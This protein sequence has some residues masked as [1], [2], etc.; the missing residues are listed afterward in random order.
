MIEAIRPAAY[1]LFAILGFLLIP[2][3]FW[4]VKR[5]LQ[6]HGTR[7]LHIGCGPHRLEGWLNTDLNPFHSLV[8]VDA[9]RRLPFDANAFD[10]IFTEHLIEHLEF[11]K[12]TQLLQECY[13]ILKAGGK[14][15][16]ATPNLQFLMDLYLPDKS[17]LQKQYIRDGMARYFPHLEMPFEAVVINH[18]FRAWGHQF[19][20]DFKTLEAEMKRAGFTGIQQEEVGESHDPRLQNLER[21]GQK[22]GQDY[23]KLET[24]VIEATKP[25]VSAPGR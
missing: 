11:R 6:S 22:I 21:H 25:F 20:Y 12:G 9:G 15:R 13:R 19:I 16:I 7:K 23:N 17:E 10:C 3:R 8:L 24:M 2:L 18:F 1:A 14:I 5:Y 4:L